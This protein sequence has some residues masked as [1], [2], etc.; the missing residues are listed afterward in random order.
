MVSGSNECGRAEVDAELQ[1]IYGPAQRALIGAGLTSVL[2]L[3][4]YLNKT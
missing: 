3:S 4:R 2:A 1:G